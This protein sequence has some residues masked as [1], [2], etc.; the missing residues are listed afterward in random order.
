MR[1]SIGLRSV[2]TYIVLLFLI[3]SI[4]GRFG[5][6]LLGLAFNLE[7]TP[8]YIPPRF[9][10]DWVHLTV[11]DRS[12]GAGA[13]DPGNSSGW[14]IWSPCLPRVHEHL[15]VRMAFSGARSS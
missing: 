3:C 12:L 10:P 13:E 4:F 8:H 2:Q 9:R 6:A 7:D 15:A 11:L 1:N 5:V 14:L